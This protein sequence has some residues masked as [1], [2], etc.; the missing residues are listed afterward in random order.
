MY[1]YIHRCT[2]CGRQSTSIILSHSCVSIQIVITFTEDPATPSN[3]VQ[4]LLNIMS[5]VDC[6]GT[7]RYDW[8]IDW[9][10]R[11]K[12]MSIVKILKKLPKKPG[13][14]GGF[15]YLA[16]WKGMEWARINPSLAFFFHLFACGIILVIFI[17]VFVFVTP[18]HVA[19]PRHDM[20]C[21]TNHSLSPS[22]HSWNLQCMYI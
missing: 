15:K 11:Q 14:G 16:R 6:P 18:L 13:R 21:K 1:M 9:L 4:Y 20:P 17:V 2:P 19:K 3:A 12:K 5:N 10:I 22:S 7:N 8:L